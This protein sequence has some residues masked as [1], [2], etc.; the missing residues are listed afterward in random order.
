VTKLLK[1]YKFR[2]TSYRPSANGRIER[3][4]RTINDLMSQMA[5]E[6]QIDWQACLPHV[7]AAYN[8]AQHET[9]RISPFFDVRKRI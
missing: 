9:T 2:T 5:S 4:H 3:V 1:V 7:V 6:G 8:A